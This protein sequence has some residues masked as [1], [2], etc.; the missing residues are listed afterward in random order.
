MATTP[1]APSS[2][3]LQRTAYIEYI[4][5]CY[6]NDPEAFSYYE[7]LVD[8]IERGTKKYLNSSEE[9]PRVFEARS[10]ISS[11]SYP[12]SFPFD[13]LEWADHSDRPRIVMLEGFPS[14]SAVLDLAQRWWLRPEFF[15]EHIF[16]SQ[17]NQRGFYSIPTLP[18][19]QE[20]IIR[21]HF[22][23]LV[24]S[25][26]EGS[27]LTSY[28]GKRSEVEEACQQYEK[29]LLNGNRYGVTRYRDIHQHDTYYC[30]VEHVTSFTVVPNKSP[31]VAVYLTDQGKSLLE[32]VRLPWTTYHSGITSL[33]SGTAVG[34]VPI[35]PYNAPI[36]TKRFD[37]SLA[38]R[39][40]SHQADSCDNNQSS[41]GSGN[42][43]FTSATSFSQLHPPRNI[44]VHDQTDMQL[45]TEDPFFLLVS[46]F[47]TSALSFTQL[48][49]Y[50]SIS[51]AECRNTEIVL[52]D[53]KLE[54]LR[55]CVRI[56]HR[57]ESALT[58]NLH[59]IARGGCDTWPRVRPGTDTATRK[60][61]L[62][63]RLRADHKALQQRCVVMRQE[64]ESAMM[65]LV[66]YS[67][68]RCGEQGTMQADEIHRLTKLTS[69]FVPLSFVTS[70]FGMNVKELQPS[71][72]SIWVFVLAAVVISATSYATM[73]WTT[74]WGLVSETWRRVTMSA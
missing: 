30:S 34:T 72:A 10:P 9:K 49:N 61:V 21:I 16:G 53:V 70:F 41:N 12:T 7:A 14:P 73:F 8:Y 54:R 25:L 55:H 17:N 15:I 11:I 23:S 27:S 31:W 39:Y 4:R 33:K 64:C 65:M 18:S 19:R 22:S 60:Q 59:W 24:K 46:L 40:L 45:L 63:A 67:Q 57:V 69:F 66:N 62:Q 37:Q 36:T 26:V 28:L 42:N 3:P 2:D 58:E 44:V 68:L 50:L 35:V 13:I 74:V 1:S 48:L 47:T 52:L 6:H 51:I 20:N 5:S 71:Y 56:I 38:A 43:G 32:D 29:Q